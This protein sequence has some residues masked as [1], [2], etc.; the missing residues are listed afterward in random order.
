VNHGRKS[1]INSTR[2][3][4][5]VMRSAWDQRFISKEND[6]PADFAAGADDGGM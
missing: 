3:A 5:A 6:D 1:E 2:E 4:M